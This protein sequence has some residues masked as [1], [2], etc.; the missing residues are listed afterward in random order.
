MAELKFDATK[1]EPWLGADHETARERALRMWMAYLNG[2][3][4]MD[5]STA[6]AL[7]PHDRD[8][9]DELRRWALSMDIAELPVAAQAAL[10]CALVRHPPRK[11]AGKMQRE[12]RV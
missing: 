5:F 11:G 1:Y 2:D 4:D 10:C 7:A 6:C 3:E 8:A 12:I 9:Y